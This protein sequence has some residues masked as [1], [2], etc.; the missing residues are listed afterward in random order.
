[1]PGYVLKIAIENTH[2]PVWRRVLVPEMI[3]FSDL[4]EI[5]QILFGWEDAHLHEFSIPSKKIYIDDGQESWGGYHYPEQETLLEELLFQNK[6]IRYTYDFGDAWRHKI[7]YEKT[8]ET[9]GDRQAVLLKYKGDNFQEDSGGLWGIDEDESN[10]EIFDS[11]LTE[12][13]LEKMVF[14]M[15]ESLIERMV[16]EVSENME[17]MLNEFVE[18]L[19][20]SIKARSKQYKSNDTLSQ[21]SKK[22][23]DWKQFMEGR[24][25]KNGEESV[26]S[27][28]F[29]QLTLP[30]V[31]KEDIEDITGSVLEVIPGKRTNAELLSDLNLKEA[32]DYCKYLQI[33]IQASFTKNQMTEAVANTFREHPEYLLYVLYEEEYKELLKWMEL[34]SGVVT[35]IPEDQ[36]A[37]IK[38]MSLGLADFSVQKS[39]G[40]CRG[41]LCFATDCREILETLNTGR[42]KQIYRS[43]KGFSQKLQR[44]ILFYG[45]IEMDSL[46][47]MFQQMYHE[48]ME[49]ETFFRYIYW[50]ARFNNLVQTAYTNEEV[51]YVAAVQIDM[52]SVLLDMKKYAHDLDYVMYSS[53]DLKKMTEDISGRNEWINGLNM[54]LH[55]EMGLSQGGAVR[56]LEAM[57]EAIMNG[58][59]LPDV[60][61]IAYAVKQGNQNLN[62]M[63]QL[64]E[65]VSFLMLEMELPMLK[66]RSRHQ[67]AQERGI[68]P[69][70]TGMVTGEQIQKDSKSRQMCEFPPEIQ[71]E[72]Y[73]A[74]C[75]ANW[76]D[77]DRLWQYKRAEKIQSEEFLYLLAS[78]CVTGCEFKKAEKLIREL[79]KSSARGEQAAAVLR[80]RLQDGMDVMDDDYEQDFPW[81]GWQ[82]DTEFIQTP[83]VRDTPKIGRNDPCP[84]GS[85]KK[86]K[87]CCGKL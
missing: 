29:E 73:R 10:R 54:I 84:C 16:N 32:K 23:N 5:I 74:C 78:A 68:S 69:W 25:R 67:Y 28:D 62:G 75:Y 39:K 86:Y 17:T 87:K 36:D 41:Y 35:E 34:P 60:L 57:F 79:E 19:C 42:R 26:Q 66:G 83:Y 40:A 76:Q 31:T 82:P 1:M 77:M 15:N 85:G 37:L 58:E 6:W 27:D 61:N 7:V 64:W 9:Y 3:T 22:V 81:N 8:E 51:G 52:E 53:S 49:R 50:Y 38:A 72:M 21:M 63:C 11:A 30:F 45:L 18:K 59:T 56:I 80:M 44:F 65:C 47:E 33:P 70:Q 55:F 2:P 43:L 48:S 71:E 14:P 12:K 20:R 24:N 13:R 46:Y 4:H